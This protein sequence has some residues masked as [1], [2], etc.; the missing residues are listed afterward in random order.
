VLAKYPGSSYVPQAKAMI[1]KL[2]EDID[3]QMLNGLLDK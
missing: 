3:D 1:A 2:S